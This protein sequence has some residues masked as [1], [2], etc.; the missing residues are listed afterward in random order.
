[1]EVSLYHRRVASRDAYILIVLLPRCTILVLEAECLFRNRSFRHSFLI[2][3]SITFNRLLNRANQIHLILTL[4]HESFPSDSILNLSHAIDS[5]ALWL[6]LQ[7]GPFDPLAL[8]LHLAD[9][10]AVLELPLVHI[11]DDVCSC[12]HFR[13]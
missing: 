5:D 11:P 1:M 9:L 13:G 12:D 2:L 4:R 3:L 6:L 8:L 7:I 10:E